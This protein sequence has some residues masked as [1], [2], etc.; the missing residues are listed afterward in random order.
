MMPTIVHFAC[1]YCG[2]PGQQKRSQ[3][4]RK[5]YHFCK[6]ACYSDYRR[7]IL[8]PEE[9]NAWTGG[10]SPEESHKRWAEK[11]QDKVKAMAKARRMREENAPGS[12]TQ[13]EWLT[14]VNANEGRCEDCGRRRPPTKDH[15]IP[16]IMGGSDDI[17]NIQ[18]LCKPCNSRKARKVYLDNLPTA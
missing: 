15:I 5:K 3:Y 8:P 1:D 4:R 16:L 17:G 9:Q 6:R 2:G 14:L 7:E 12:H 10:V 11:N 18:V 13:A